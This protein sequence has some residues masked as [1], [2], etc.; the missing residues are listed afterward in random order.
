M[1]SDRHLLICAENHLMEEA[2]GALQK[3]AGIITAGTG[4]P[5]SPAISVSGCEA[6]RGKKVS[7]KENY[8][9]ATKISH[10]SS[11]WQLRLHTCFSLYRQA[12]GFLV[13]FAIF[14]ITLRTPGSYSNISSQI[15]SFIFAAHVLQLTLLGDPNTT[16]PKET[17]LHITFQSHFFRY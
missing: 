7:G 1:A 3:Q 17:H 5:A 10:I 6:K 14:P 13:C 11:V 9:I 15:R 16:T 4:P 12:P 8:P 2:H